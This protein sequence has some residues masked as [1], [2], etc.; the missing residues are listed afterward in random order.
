M[1]DTRFLPF[2]ATALLFLLFRLQRSNINLQYIP[3][4][5][6][7]FL[8]FGLLFTGLAVLLLGEWILLLILRVKVHGLLQKGEKITYAKKVFFHLKTPDGK[9]FSNPMSP[10]EGLDTSGG[11]VASAGLFLTS[12]GRLLLT[13]TRTKNN[14]F[15]TPYFVTL[16]DLDKSQIKEMTIE[17]SDINTGGL[18]SPGVFL[19]ITT[20]EGKY[21][22]GVGGPGLSKLFDI[23]KIY[24]F[25]KARESIKKPLA[26][27][28]KRKL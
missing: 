9:T 12:E 25:K 5:D 22:L 13:G 15:S 2:I 18:P 1:F 20:A 19:N 27:F 24:T 3:L 26:T 17:D 23:S 21:E 11:K 8:G 14:F 6:L 4:L 10:T 28:F 7:V 16:I